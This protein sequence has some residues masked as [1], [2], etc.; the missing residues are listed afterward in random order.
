MS[1]RFRFTV[2]DT[3]AEK[4]KGSV[5][6]SLNWGLAG[7]GV[8]EMTGSL[9]F[10]FLTPFT[11]WI[12]TLFYC[13]V[14]CTLRNCFSRFLSPWKSSFSPFLRQISPHFSLGLSLFSPPPSP[15]ASHFYIKS[16]VLGFVFKQRY[17]KSARKI[18][19]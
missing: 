10:P 14:L 9:N 15:A 18:A 7:A 12:Q 3:I 8:G 13:K 16:F 5:Q 19:N 17:K 2:L 4:H 11:S 6:L 1:K